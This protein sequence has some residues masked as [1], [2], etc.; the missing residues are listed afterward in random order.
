M[1]IRLRGTGAAN[2][3][4]YGMGMAENVSVLFVATEMVNQ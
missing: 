1:L 3:R 4:A 2:A